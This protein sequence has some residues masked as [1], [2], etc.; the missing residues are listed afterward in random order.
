MRKSRQGAA[1]NREKVVTTAS[2]MFREEGY[3][4]VGI[5]A[6]M[7]VAGLTNGAFYKQF[8][9]KEA[10]IAEATG[11]ALE[12]NVRAWEKVLET[13][14]DDPIDAVVSFGPARQAARH[15]LHLRIACRRGAAP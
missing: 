2:K 10:L 4:G 12:E 8:D 3:D 14:E 9:S 1:E 7:K 5:A 11:H 6:L 15:R 13:A